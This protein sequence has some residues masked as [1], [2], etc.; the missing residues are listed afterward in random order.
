MCALSSVPFHGDTSTPSLSFRGIS[1]T[2]V[3]QNNQIWITAYDLASALGY[4]DPD[5]VTRIYNRNKNE[6]TD[7]MS[8]TVNLTRTVSS[9]VTGNSTGTVNSAVTV[10]S[11]GTVSSTGTDATS[12]KI[13]PNVVRLFTPRGCHLIAMFSRTKVSKDFRKW[14]LDVL[15]KYGQKMFSESQPIEET[16]LPTPPKEDVEKPFPSYQTYVPPRE[17]V[18]FDARGMTIKYM[19]HHLL[20]TYLN[21][22]YFLAGSDLSKALGSQDP[23][24]AEQIFKR[25]QDE[26]TESMVEIL[27]RDGKREAYFSL[28]A[29]HMIAS[30]TVDTTGLLAVFRKWL[31]CIRERLDAESREERQPIYR[32]GAFQIPEAKANRI[33]GP[34]EKSLLQLSRE[35]DVHASHLESIFKEFSRKVNKYRSSLYPQAVSDMASSTDTA[36]SPH[37]LLEGL[38][39]SADEADRHFDAAIRLLS[40]YLRQSVCLAAVQKK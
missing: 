11:A 21:G 22:D 12:N 28:L 15:D 4:K 20:F 5:S 8:V 9:T 26:F 7:D 6:F 10:N 17:N 1:L 2:P 34:I 40:T 32:D 38:Y 36:F 19:G 37:P 14:A 3:V 24:Y 33:P 25:R 27:E 13:I 18:V 31:L 30:Y 35:W 16:H 39:A 23:L 29:C